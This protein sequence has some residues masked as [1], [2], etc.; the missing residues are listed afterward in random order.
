MSIPNTKSNT[1]YWKIQNQIL[2]QIP[3]TG[4]SQYQIPNQIPNT[5][6]SRNQI[7]NQIPILG[8]LETKYQIKYQYWEISE[9]NTK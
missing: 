2:N 7:P 8:N 4:K 6:N 1:K 9:P 3:N 5:G